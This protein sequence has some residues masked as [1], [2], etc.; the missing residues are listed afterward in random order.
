VPAKVAAVENTNQK[1]FAPPG[2]QSMD[3]AKVFALGG[4]AGPSTRP[5]ARS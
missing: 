1:F 5:T 2:G 3:L 4:A